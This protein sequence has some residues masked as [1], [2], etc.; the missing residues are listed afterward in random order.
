MDPN[1]TKGSKKGLIAAIAA[2]LVIVCAG[3]GYYAYVQKIEGMRNDGA[4]ALQASVDLSNY[5]EAEQAEITEIIEKTEASR[6][7]SK[8]QAEIDSMVEAA[9][10][11]IGT[12]KSDSEY[13]KEEGIEKLKKSVDLDLYRDA[14]QKEIKEILDSTQK[15]IGEAKDQAEVDALIEKA[16]TKVG[17]LKTDAQYTE[18]AAAAAAAA[19]RSGKKKKSKSSGGCIGGGDVWN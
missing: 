9:V 13:I 18:E 11:E 3:G 5:R 2:L 14:E 4:A 6:R 8:D 15:S 16:V 1:E 17:E 7:G 10:A 12:F 19:S